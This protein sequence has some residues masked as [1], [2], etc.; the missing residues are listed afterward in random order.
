MGV[1]ANS[2]ECIPIVGIWTLQSPRPRILVA[3]KIFGEDTGQHG[4]QR[5]NGAPGR[6]RTRNPWVRSPVLCPL[7]YERNRGV[8]PGKLGRA[9]GFEPVISCATDRRL[10]HWATLAVLV[11][12]PVQGRNSPN[13]SNPTIQ[14]YQKGKRVTRRQRANGNRAGPPQGMGRRPDLSTTAVK[15]LKLPNLSGIPRNLR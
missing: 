10:Y 2:V 13:A 3:R 5:K 8:S 1:S 6:T 11:V 15:W 9:T 12:L 14:S 4:N 7:S